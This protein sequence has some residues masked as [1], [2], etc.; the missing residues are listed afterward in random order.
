MVAT[1]E[2]SS[3][4]VVLVHHAG[5]TIESEPVELELLHPV[6][7]IAEQESYNLVRPIVEEAAVPEIVTSLS[8]L[9]EIEVVSSIELVETVQDVLA[10]MGVHDIEKDSNTQSMGRVDQFFEFFRGSVSRA[11]REEARNLVS[12]GWKEQ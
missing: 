5:H 8:S 1:R 3:D 6:A 12:E 2:T 4:T 11:R 9:M 10:C 7:K